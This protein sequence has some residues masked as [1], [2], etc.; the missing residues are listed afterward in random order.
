[1]T[2]QGKYA[3]F[4]EGVLLHLLEFKVTKYINIDIIDIIDIF[5]IIITIITIIV[6]TMIFHRRKAAT[7]GCTSLYKW[8]ATHWYHGD[9]QCVPLPRIMNARTMEKLSYTLYHTIT[10]VDQIVA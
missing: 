1:M 2:V 5:I 9:F 4:K 3:Q 8:V 6:I 7:H 10:T